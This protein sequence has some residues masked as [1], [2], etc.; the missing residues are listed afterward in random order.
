MRAKNKQKTSLHQS[1]KYNIQNQ[2]TAIK[3]MSNESVTFTALNRNTDLPSV[4]D[5]FMNKP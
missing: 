3:S 1:N 5:L 2:Y 4:D